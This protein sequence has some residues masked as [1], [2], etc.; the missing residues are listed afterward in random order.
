MSISISAVGAAAEALE[1]LERLRGGARSAGRRRRRRPRPRG[2]PHT[3]ASR[4]RRGSPAV[5]SK[6]SDGKVTRSTGRCSRS[7][8]PPPARDPPR[9]VEVG[10][11]GLDDRRSTGGRPR[12]GA[13]S[14]PAA[15]ASPMQRVG[16]VEAA[17]LAHQS[18]A[19]AAQVAA[20]LRPAPARTRRLRPGRPG[21]WRRCRRAARSAD[22][23]ASRTRRGRSSQVS[24][25]ALALGIADGPRHATHH[26]AHV[27]LITELPDQLPQLRLSRP[28]P[29]ARR[30]R[31]HADLDAHSAA[32]CRDFAV[33]G[34]KLTFV[35]YPMRQHRTPAS[36]I[37]GVM[38]SPPQADQG[39]RDDRHAA[40]EPLPARV[41]ARQRRDVD[42]LP[43]GRRDARPPG[44]GQDHAPRDLR[45]AGP[46]RALP[47]RG[48]GGRPALPP[49][50]RRRDRRRRGRRPP[51][52]RLRVRPRADAEGADRRERP[53]AAR[54]GDRLRDRDRPRPRQPPTPRGSSTATSSR[55]TS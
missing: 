51:L 9:L 29:G 54:R 26:P 13:T 15:P 33:A 6:V 47:P 4:G 41:E 22:P 20:R 24:R 14:R 12:S 46:A 39:A 11:E 27:Q 49:Q 38:K 37:L 1:D 48:A 7:P 21:M 43:G 25:V 2:T 52:H 5:A 18:L 10:P 8:P 36:K 50:P 55:R 45:P 28:R 16:M 44:R 30:V 40:L 23:S 32:L 19:E 17:H 35:G 3:A 53:A 31:D 34:R 42:R